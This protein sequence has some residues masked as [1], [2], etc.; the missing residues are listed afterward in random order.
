MYIERERERERKEKKTESKNRESVFVDVERADQRGVLDPAGPPPPW[1][2]LCK[3]S[4]FL[5]EPFMLGPQ[6]V[7]VQFTHLRL[8]CLGPV[9]ILFKPDQLKT[10]L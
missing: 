3:L 10:V 2:Y 6:V 8:L 9:C 7:V 5:L 4:S 1:T